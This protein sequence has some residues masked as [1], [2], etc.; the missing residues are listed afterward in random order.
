MGQRLQE[1]I[2]INKGLL[3]LGNV[4]CALSEGK[5]H[6]PYRDSKLTRMLQVGACRLVGG[7]TGAQ[8]RARGQDRGLCACCYLAVEPRRTLSPQFTS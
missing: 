7:R 4:I 1:G 3:A 2:N 6:V 5:Q 8:A